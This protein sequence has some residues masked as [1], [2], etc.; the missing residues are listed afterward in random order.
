MKINTG[1][2]E[3]IGLLTL[4]AIYSVSVV[5][6]L[7]GL[8]ISPILGELEHIFPSATQFQLQLLASISSLIVVP[9]ILLS[10]RLSINR[11]RKTILVIG[12]GLF[13]LSSALYLSAKSI[14]SLLWISVLLGIGAGMIIPLSKG[15][16]AIYFSGAQRQRQLGIS[17]GVT[18]MSLV[19]ATFLTGELAD[20]DWHWAFLV[21]MFSA[22]SLVLV[23][24]L[25]P[26]RNVQPTKGNVK[27]ASQTPLP[28]DIDVTSRTDGQSQK[29]TNFKMPWALMFFYFTLCVMVLAIPIELSLFIE[30]LKIGTSADSGLLI[31]AFFLAIT[32]PGFTLSYLI[33]ML[34]R[35]VNVISTSL[36]FIGMMT[37][38]FSH[39]MWILAAGAVAAGFGYGIMQPMVYE[40]AVVNVSKH[41]ATYALSWVMTMNYLSIIFYPLALKWLNSIFSTQSVYVP[42]GFSFIISAVMLVLVFIRRHHR[43]LGQEKA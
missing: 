6:S 2:G 25:R 17:S 21:Y 38:L 1:S 31:A 40:K 42:F 8:A 18:N 3:P 33:R 9:F 7:P 23:L 26:N 16:I 14:E 30:Q 35:W 39:N 11:D 4:C 24:F 20:I 13:L 5:I 12:L 43:V 29:N 32:I 36:I 37:F 15:L 10:G 19:I 34:G 22:V 28:R 41:Q 27:V